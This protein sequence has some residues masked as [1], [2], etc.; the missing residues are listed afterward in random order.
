MRNPVIKNASDQD[1][2][3]QNAKSAARSHRIPNQLWWIK[4]LP[5]YSIAYIAAMK[6]GPTNQTAQ[7]NR[8]WASKDILSM[9]NTMRTAKWPSDS[10]EI[11]NGKDDL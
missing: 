11:T 2:E 7:I 8:F 3:L 4:N 5:P 9:S 6:N 10:K 1:L